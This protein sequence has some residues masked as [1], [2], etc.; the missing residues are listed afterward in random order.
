MKKLPPTVTFQEQE[1]LVYKDTGDAG[2]Q[3]LRFKD[4]HFE[5]EDLPKN[6]GQGGNCLT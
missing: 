5:A 2:Q 6:M 3:T 4:V 1:H